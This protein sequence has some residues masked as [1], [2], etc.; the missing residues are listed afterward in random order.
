M[1]KLMALWLVVA[2]SGCPDVDVDPD[3]TVA[4]PTVEFDPARSLATGARFIP[5]PNDL[6]RDP[7][8][9]KINLGPQNCE[10]PTAKAT[11]E[12]ILNT[13]DGFGTYQ[14]A[15]QVT[16]TSEV[17][18]A[19]LADHVVMVQLTHQGVPI[20][21]SASTQPIPLVVA[22]VGKTPRFATADC[23]T[24]ELVDSVTFVPAV[25]LEQKSTYF[26]A[27]LRGIKN[28]A[29]EEF[30]PAY[31][32][33]LVS[34][35][36]NPV[37][38][39]DRGNIVS[40]RT[41]LDPADPEARA[42]L[43]A[44]A[45]LWQL[46]DPGLTFV[47]ALT[48]VVRTDTLVGFQF[49][50]QTVTDPLDPE[51]AGSP[52]NTLGSVGLLQPQSV[53]NKFG[54]YSALCG[55]EA[56]TNPAQ[57]FLKLALGGCSPLTTG[58][59]VNN[60]NAGTQACQLYNCAAIGDIIGGGIATPNYQRQLPN[61]LGSAVP[62]VQG[63]WSDPVDPEAQGTL[64]LETI[65]VLP[66][67]NPPTRGWPT[68][69]F[70]HGL[71]AS[72][73]SVFAIAGM[74]AARG[75]ATVAI[76]ASAHGS[77]AVR[78]SR[79]INLGCRGMCFSGTT[80][81]GTECDTITECNAGETCGS[82]AATPSLVPP[83]PT[84]APQCYAPFLSA[85]LA[86]TRDGIRQTNLDHER[87]VKALATCGAAGCGPVRVDPDRISFVGMS[88]G[89]II[90]TTS[91]AMS[92]AIQTAV[93]DVGGVGWVDIL[94]NTQT[95]QIR[96]ALVN[97]LIDAGILVGEKWTGGSTGLCTTDEWKMQPG[98][99][100]FSAIARWVLDPAEPAN[101]EARIL[102]ADKK[103]L[104]Q[105]VV[106]DTVVPNIATE[107]QAALLGLPTM[108]LEADPFNPSQPA[109][110]AAIVEMPN[111]RKF[112]K[113]TSDANNVFVHSSLLRP[114][115]TTNPQAGINGTL[116]LQ[117]DASSYLFLNQ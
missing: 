32:W 28:A 91:F 67:G 51:V 88:L 10:S 87:V 58:C 72:K 2:M 76:D 71:G 30:A 48:G 115:A 6:A 82:T 97:G 21:P 54:P 52:A 77:R 101:F 9:G 96:C 89:A 50:T 11:R 105:E 81:T 84:T 70:A 110:S 7:A 24:P 107:R 40:D 18:R 98:Y 78:I 45:G 56:T 31:T 16:F 93:L 74:L 14:T 53:T 73:E 59:G 85:D 42:Q 41:P 62:A 104:I 114:A 23:N 63:A 109:P 117:V 66:A 103:V 86:T 20:V 83:S 8:T 116:R 106:G 39:D 13:L 37:T 35:T 94:E 19:S 69:V 17:D 68:V 5:F 4:V 25:P 80:P 60:Y 27:L 65:V 49:T 44:L 43:V 47:E 57:C 26:V 33:G 92:P 3:E 1:N 99:A 34:S 29:G 112:V 61:P 55:A 46:H 75:F 95:L 113:Y 36:E 108:S 100:T 12:N 22:R 111:T 90:G 64:I 102:A 15:L 38:L 79:D